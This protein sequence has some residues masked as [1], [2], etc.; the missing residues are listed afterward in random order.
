MRPDREELLKILKDHQG[1]KRIQ[2]VIKEKT[3]KILKIIKDYEEEVKDLDL[4]LILE[5]K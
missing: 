2:K 4:F 3:E 1:E 5:R